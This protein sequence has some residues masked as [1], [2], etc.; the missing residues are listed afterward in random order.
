MTVKQQIKDYLQQA[1]Y[2]QVAT[3]A[4]GQPWVCTVHFVEDDDMNLYWLS[5]PSRRHS[6]EI[7]SHNKIAVTVPIKF[8]LPVVGIQAEGIAEV[9]QEPARIEIVMKK[10]VEKYDIGQAFYDNFIAGKNQHAMYRF[11]PGKYFLFDEVN[12]PGEGR[13][14]VDFT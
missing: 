3:V 12:Y 5:L 13:K 2:M 6:L 8:D 11:N 1:N 7:A 14:A 9:V 10:Y 4:G